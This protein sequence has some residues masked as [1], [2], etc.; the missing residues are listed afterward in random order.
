MFRKSFETSLIIS[1]EIIK[2]ARKNVLCKSF[3]IGKKSNFNFQNRRYFEKKKSKSPQVA[4][5]FFDLNHQS[6]TFCA[7]A[8]CTK[9]FLLEPLVLHVLCRSLV[10]LSLQREREEEG[11]RERERRGDE[12]GREGERRQ[13]ERGGESA[14]AVCTPNCDAPSPDNRAKRGNE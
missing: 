14:E 5:P 9:A 2:F 1:S 4:G 10:H 11:E 7:E 6:C 12:G 8:V 3:S 13:R